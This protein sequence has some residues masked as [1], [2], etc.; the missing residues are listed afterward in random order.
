MGSWLSGLVRRD[1][2][3]ELRAN[4][5]S[6]GSQRERTGAAVTGASQLLWRGPVSVASQVFENL[7]KGAR[8]LPQRV[9]RALILLRTSWSRLSVG[10]QG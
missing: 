9:P 1:V 2:D 6:H 4:G 5:R 3:L 10:R 8:L 7:G